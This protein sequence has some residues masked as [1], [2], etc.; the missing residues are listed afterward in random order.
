MILDRR[1]PIAKVQE[2]LLGI[3]TKYLKALETNSDFPNMEQNFLTRTK[4]T[5]NILKKSNFKVNLS[6]NTSNESETAQIIET[7]HYMG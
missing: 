4:N 5:L 7:T 3:L 2:D 6:K 1:Y